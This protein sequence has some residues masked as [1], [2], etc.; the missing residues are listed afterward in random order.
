MAKLKP[1]PP[2]QVRQTKQYLEGWHAFEREESN[3]ENPYMG[4]NGPFPWY[5]NFGWED[6][7]AHWVRTI[8]KERA[9]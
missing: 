1:I 6:A 8:Q 4:D 5:W 7:M 2:E 9:R 3:T